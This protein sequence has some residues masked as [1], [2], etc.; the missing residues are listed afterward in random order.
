MRSSGSRLRLLGSSLCFLPLFLYLTSSS[1]SRDHDSHCLPSILPVSQCRVRRPRMASS[2]QR[3]AIAPSSLAESTEQHRHTKGVLARQYHSAPSA[4]LT[5][6]NNTGYCTLVRKW[7]PVPSCP[8]LRLLP[9]SNVGSATRPSPGL[10]TSSATKKATIVRPRI[11]GSASIAKEAIPEGLLN[12][13]IHPRR[14]RL[15][16]TCLPQRRTEQTLVS[17]QVRSS[18]RTRPFVSRE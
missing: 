11:A 14:Y 9:G 7:L 1:R 15:S 8:T 17:L 2:D 6:Q 13:H 12:Q 10:H 16:L 18:R 3:F 5:R 4:I